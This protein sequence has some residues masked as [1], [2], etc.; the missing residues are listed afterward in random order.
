MREIYLYNTL[1]RRKERLEPREPGK[2]CMYVC[3][4]TPYSPCHL[5]HARCYLAYDMIRRYL[6]Y[7]GYEVFHVQNFTDVD[8]KIIAQA[9]EEG[10]AVADLAA[11][12]IAEYFRDMDAL[13]VKRAHRYPRVT[14]HIPDII[15]VVQALVEKE[16]AYVVEG[17]V[18]LEVRKI[19]D[20]GKLSGQTLD[21]LRAGASERV[22]VDERKRDPLDF[23]LWKA[24]KPDEPQWESPWGPGR[25]GWHIEC[26]VMSLKYLGP[27]FD[28]H[29]GGPDLIFPHHENEIAQS[30]AY[31]GKSFVRYW[32]H[33]GLLN[34]RGEKM[35]KSLRNYFTV[36][37]ALERYEPDVVRLYLLSK[38]YRS[39]LDFE[40]RERDGEVEMPQLEEAA[41]A[42]ERVQLTLQQVERAVACPPVVADDPP[43]LKDLQ[44]R[45][46]AT[47]E[48][49][50]AALSDD[51]N[52]AAAIG[53]LFSLVGELNRML[54]ASDFRP[55]DGV[56]AALSAGRDML[57]ELGGVLG[58]FQQSRQEP[59]L[60]EDLSAELL[61]V[62]ISVRQQ[63]RERRDWATAD[64]IRDRLATLGV[65]LEDRPEGTTWRRTKKAAKNEKNS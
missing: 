65:V 58:L 53:S 29:G 28:I 59:T 45:L 23:A 46:T 2:I 27:G 10:V 33:N 9:R 31:T 3:G 30:E 48:R 57:L 34:V 8:D 63:A 19:P 60:G 47:E 62:L 22:E 16:Y 12:M 44:F 26:S 36:Q 7:C 43:Q 25:P 15:E 40:L 18:Y 32:L 24:A 4:V 37:A 21:E 64:A 54:N 6:E 41:R 35:S 55:T 1:T 56:Q 38:H 52:S 13:G 14:A 51:F 39:S 20:Y 11:R 5:G 42:L 17:D 50:H 61:K 49:F